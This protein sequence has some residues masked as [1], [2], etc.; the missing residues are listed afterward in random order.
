M[1]GTAF[2]DNQRV[3]QAVFRAGLIDGATLQ[4]ALQGAP[5]GRLAEWLVSRGR[6]RREDLLRAMSLAS[7]RYPTQPPPSPARDPRSSSSAGSGV[8]A[9]PPPTAHG[10]VAPHPVTAMESSATV[11]LAGGSAAPPIPTA[12]P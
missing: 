12:P 11:Y 4:A 2:A 1:D 7:G 8:H 3:A 9:V 6:V 10:A 5:P